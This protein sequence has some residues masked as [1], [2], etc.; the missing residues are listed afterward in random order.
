MNKII[1]SSKVM[2]VRVMRSYPN[3]LFAYPFQFQKVPY[4]NFPNV[5][6]IQVKRSYGSDRRA[7][8]QPEDL[9][10]FK[11]VVDYDFLKIE[12]HLEKGAFLVIP[13]TSIGTEPKIR[14]DT[15][16]PKLYDYLTNKMDKLVDIYGVNVNMAL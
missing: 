10:E 16:A 12:L 2:D 3:F 9:D 6:P 7:F 15:K 5:A 1:K 13:L 4:Y 8:W 14:L 11:K